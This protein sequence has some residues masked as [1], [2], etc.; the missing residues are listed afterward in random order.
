M[1]SRTE[2][3]VP[4]GMSL[5]ALRKYPEVRQRRIL[6]W[7]SPQLT[8]GIS[9]RWRYFLSCVRIESARER[10]LKF[11]RCC[12]RVVGL[13]PGTREITW[14]GGVRYGTTCS[15]FVRLM[16]GKVRTK[17]LFRQGRELTFYESVVSVQ[18][19]EVI[20]FLGSKLAAL[21]LATDVVAIHDEDVLRVAGSSEF[22][23]HK[24]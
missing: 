23:P 15:T 5:A 11:S 16:Q 14:R 19:G 9:N 8:I 2:R 1:P 21:E 4:S 7:S 18:V 24:S 12:G 13:K 3:Y 22:W 20:P 10:A 17:E 6:L